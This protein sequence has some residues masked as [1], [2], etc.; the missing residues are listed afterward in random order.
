MKKWECTVCG[1]IHEGDEPPEICPVCGA[2]KS[3]FIEIVEGASQEKQ[4]VGPVPEVQ[5]IGQADSIIQD[6]AKAAPVQQTDAMKPSGSK[7]SRF[8]PYIEPVLK[9][10]VKYHAHP[11]SVHIP[12]GVLPV[13]VIFLMLAVMFNC[14]GLESAA[15]YNLIFV[16]LSMPLVIF[17][18][19]NDWKRRYRGNISN[20]FLGKM[21]CGGIVSVFSI[22]LVVWRTVN[23]DVVLSA[24]PSRWSYLVFHLI[25]LAAAIVAGALGGKLV[26]PNSRDR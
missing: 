18:G 25:M 10:M 1:Y 9:F 11:I 23:P 20:L 3:M 6:D 24:S 14:P 22:F 7:W 17:S 15:F 19:V 12:N 4:P 26:F 16:A 13:S 21:I 8:G 2:D 5:Q